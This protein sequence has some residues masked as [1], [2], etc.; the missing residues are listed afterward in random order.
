[1]T[2]QECVNFVVTGNMFVAQLVH[3]KQ[4]LHMPWLVMGLLEVSFVLLTLLGM[5]LNEE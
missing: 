5:E 1:M 4:L 3:D 2:Q